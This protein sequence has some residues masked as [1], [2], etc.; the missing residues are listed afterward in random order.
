[1]LPLSLLMR[2]R[3]YDHPMKCLNVRTGQHPERELQP[4]TQVVCLNLDKFGLLGSIH[5]V[6]QRK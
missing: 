2:K 4:K 5:T 6:D 3:D 1:V